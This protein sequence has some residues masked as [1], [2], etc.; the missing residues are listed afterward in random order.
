MNTFSQTPDAKI[1]SQKLMR[2]R[3]RIDLNVASLPE[4]T[5]YEQLLVQSG[6]THQEII[7]HISK[8]GYKSWQEYYDERNSTGNYRKRKTE[9]AILGAILG[10]A[11]AA[12]VF[13][14]IRS[15]QTQYA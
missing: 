13:L 10:L 11:L 9:G 4:Y 15:R 1:I 2:L 3:E 8:H 12:I 14:A 6:Y 7:D 5:E